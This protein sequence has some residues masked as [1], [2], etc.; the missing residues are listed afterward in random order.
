M[1][2]SNAKYELHLETHMPN[3]AGGKYNVKV[4]K[5]DACILA[6]ISEDTFAVHKEKNCKGGE[7]INKTFSNEANDE[8][9]VQDSSDVG[10]DIRSISQDDM[11][12]DGTDAVQDSNDTSLNISD[13]KKDLDD[14]QND[15]VMLFRTVAVQ[16]SKIGTKK[17]QKRGRKRVPKQ[18]Y[19]CEVCNYAHTGIKGLLDHF[20]TMSHEAKLCEANGEEKSFQCV[21]C[22]EKFYTNRLLDAHLEKHV[23]TQQEFKICAFCDAQVL[24][25]EYKEHCK[26]AGHEDL[27]Q[28]KTFGFK[29]NICDKVMMSSTSLAD[30]KYIHTG[31][32]P[33]K[34]PMCS[35]RS[36]R[37]GDIAIHIK[38]HLGIK[39]FKCDQC[40][41]TFV[42]KSS[43]KRHLGTH[44]GKDRPRD[45]KC[46]LCDATFFN[47]VILRI[48][49]RNVHQMEKPR[50]Y[51]DVQGCTHGCRS[52]SE[53]RAH[54]RTHT[55]D[56]P[57]LCTT[58]GK[59]TASR[60][61]MTIHQRIHTGDKPF[62]CTYEGCSYAA[63][64]DSHLRRHILVHT[65]A[66]P[67]KCP[68][69]DYRSNVQENLRKHIKNSRKHKGM[70]MYKCNRCNEWEGDTMKEMINHIRGDHGVYVKRLDVANETGI[71]QKNVLVESANS[72][73]EEPPVAES[74]NV[75]D[76]AGSSESNE[77]DII[78]IPLM[79]GDTQGGLGYEQMENE[80]LRIAERDVVEEHRDL[81]NPVSQARTQQL[82]VK[83]EERVGD[84]FNSLMAG[85]LG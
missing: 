36:R 80:E 38:R 84:I 62:K 40:D 47:R 10:Q 63:R 15:E 45:I 52:H 17:T 50:F 13:V 39:P 11:T 61:A 53:L 24:R 48:H 34:C 83:L 21:R 51:C 72:E 9:A 28:Q 35:F 66:K 77:L 27:V 60:K 25:D 8:G 37:K 19:A 79:Q 58:C 59:T 23:Q 6:F 3:N 7:N 20:E 68:H 49:H 71:F 81:M 73:K 42:K 2:S 43:L 14:E 29:C 75:I 4:F 41:A 33:H 78:N 64:F 54:K 74:S 18:L 65:G 44:L 16:N 26:N 85:G 32:R 12:Q 55:K 5:C 46:D 69:C 56:R 1:F 57:F 70:K 22:W 67:Y 76:D 82:V 30:H 31:Q